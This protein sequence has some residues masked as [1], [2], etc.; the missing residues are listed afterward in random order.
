[1]SRL[2]RLIVL[3]L[4]V[5]SVVATRGLSQDVEVATSNGVD[6]SFIGGNVVIEIKKPNSLASVKFEGTVSKVSG[7]VAIVE[8]PKMVIT[9]VRGVPMLCNIPIIG[10]R[11]F[12]CAL[13]PTTEHV[14]GNL[15]LRSPT[16]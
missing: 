3:S 12:Q 16:H 14:A 10:K 5:M 7:N 13:E 1:M 9:K 6:Q 2:S 15:I 11:Y 8:R 4:V